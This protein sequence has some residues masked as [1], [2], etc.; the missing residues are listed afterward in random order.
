M[1]QDQGH[2]DGE[3]ANLESI[4]QVFAEFE[5]D[6]LSEVGGLKLHFKWMN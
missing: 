4:R 1:P 5:A 2:F 3:I 6:F